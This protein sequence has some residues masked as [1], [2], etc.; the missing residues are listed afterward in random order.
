MIWLLALVA[1]AVTIWAARA[2]ES[3]PLPQITVEQQRDYY[4]ARAALL[5][6]PQQRALDDIISGMQAICADRGLMADAKGDPMC[7]SKAQPE[8]AK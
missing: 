6:T 8:K 1:I 3:A 5:A 7:G 4:R 2:E